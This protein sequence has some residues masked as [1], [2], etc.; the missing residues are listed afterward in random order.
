MTNHPERHKYGTEANRPIRRDLERINQA[1]HSHDRPYSWGLTIFRTVYTSESNDSFPQAV[2]SLHALANEY[3]LGELSL[4]RG[5]LEPP[6][7][8]APNEALAKRFYCDVIQDKSVLD[9]VGPDTV[10][11]LFD[12]WVMEH[13]HD[14]GRRLPECA[15]FGRSVGRFEFCIML[16]QQGIDHLLQM[17]IPLRLQMRRCGQ[18][19]VKVVAAVK[20]QDLGEHGQ[21]DGH[22]TGRL[23][24]R[25]GLGIPII[26]LC[27]GL[28]DVDASLDELGLPD[29]VDGILNYFMF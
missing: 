8:P 15:D 13:N 25:A 10:G 5:R 3:A 19:Y 28:I 24:L 6:L 22:E 9:G 17:K 14:K 4:K 18:L 7:D 12:A 23:W 16:D 29:Q 11:E 26:R 20:R 2:E 27:I 1:S 21:V